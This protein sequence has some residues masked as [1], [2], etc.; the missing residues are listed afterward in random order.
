MNTLN[1]YKSW[2]L[3][4]TDTLA[5]VSNYVKMISSFLP[6]GVYSIKNLVPWEANSFL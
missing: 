2:F 5:R 3:R 4:G 6:I 1:G